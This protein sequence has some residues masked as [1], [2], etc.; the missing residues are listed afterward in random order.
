MLLAKAELYL[1][2]LQLNKGNPGQGKIGVRCSVTDVSCS[3]GHY[4][5]TVQGD[6]LSSSQHASQ[7][8]NFAAEDT[9]ERTTSS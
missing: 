1:V 6:V 9:M 8:G 4:R 7:H 3:R 5:L 2:P